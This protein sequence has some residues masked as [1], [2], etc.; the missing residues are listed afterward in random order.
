MQNFYF[1][2]RVTTSCL[3]AICGFV[4]VAFAK[5][6]WLALAGV[7]MTSLASGL[8]EPTFLAYSAYFNKNVISTWS[9]GTGGAGII[10]ALAYSVLKDIGLD[11][12][13]TLLVGS[14][15]MFDFFLKN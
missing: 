10:G 11:N 2:V 6:Q 12:R 14:T 4:A 9:S 15:K 13:Q 7:G 3:I 8:G 1:R 5:T